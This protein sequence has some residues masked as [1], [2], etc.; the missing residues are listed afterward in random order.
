MKLIIPGQPIPAARMTGRSKWT[1]QQAIR[2]NEYKK[3]VAEYAKYV[4]KI[5]HMLKGDM[6]LDMTFLR[7]GSRRA[8]WDNL[9]KAI[10]DGLNG[11]V[12]L[13]DKQVVKA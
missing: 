12:Y 6:A 8:D 10:S 11:V 4:Y 7:E 1:D 5:D 9:G 2:S 3:A 13:D